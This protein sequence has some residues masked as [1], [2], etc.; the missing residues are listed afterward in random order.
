[1]RPISLIF[2]TILIGCTEK[3]TSDTSDTSTSPTTDQVE[4]TYTCENDED[5]CYDATSTVTLEESEFESYLD[6]DGQLTE[7]NCQNICLDQSVPASYN[8]CGCSYDGINEFGDP[9][10]TCITYECA[11]EGRGHGEIQKADKV[12]GPNAM[13]RW[14][15]RA[16]HA[17]ASSVGSFLQ[18][19]AELQ[20]LHAPQSLLERCMKAAKEEVMHARMMSKYCAK[21]GGQ[22]PNL[23]FGSIP[24]RN[25][26]DLALDNA[27]EGCIFETYAALRAHYQSKNATDVRIRKIM[28][29]IARDETEHAQLAWDIHHWL[30]PQLTESQKKTIKA[31][32]QQAFIELRKSATHAAQDPMATEL[33]LPSSQ[34]AEDLYVQIA[35]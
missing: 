7:E 1:M 29:V 8:I 20:E 22:A 27:V 3:E 19:K 35:A 30:L 14:F 10:I 25:L 2:S 21:E 16:F 31:A 34:L 11:V 18:L 28:K 12:T 4:F 32:Q 6:A 15:A 26:F 24:T 23:D 17:E 33:G 5:W 13:A 9:A